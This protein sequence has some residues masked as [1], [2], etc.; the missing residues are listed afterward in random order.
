MGT[1]SPS[2]ACTV[3]RSIPSGWGRLR[4]APSSSAE[5]AKRGMSRSPEQRRRTVSGGLESL[6]VCEDSDMDRRLRRLRA[7]PR[8]G[9]G[10]VG[11][12]NVEEW[13]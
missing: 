6:S 4:A 13:K 1:G 9:P 3:D 2:R 12:I 10:S 8:Q 5:M 7:E 11:G